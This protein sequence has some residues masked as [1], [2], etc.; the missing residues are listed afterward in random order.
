MNEKAYEYLERDKLHHIDMIE[1]LNAKTAEVLYAEDDG[2]LLYNVPSCAFMISTEQRKTLDRMCEIMREASL[3]IIHQIQ[4]LPFL[5][6]RFGLEERMECFQCAYFGNKGLDEHIPEGVEL[7]PLEISELEFVLKN[8][9]HDAEE[10]YI[11]ERIKAGMIGA[12][13]NGEPAGFIGTHSEGS[14]GIL[15]I[16]PEYRRKGIAYSLEASLINRILSQGGIPYAQI[17]TSNEASLRLQKK[18]G[19]A[20]SDKTVGWLY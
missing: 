20:F 16:L 15:K 3:M 14:M 1:S 19:M 8:Y 13:C 12:F 7:R 4:F 2:V 6:E 10:D 5:R 9:E 11:A 17:V 18:L